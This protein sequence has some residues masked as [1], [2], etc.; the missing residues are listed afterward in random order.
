MITI[1][2]DSELTN[3]VLGISDG[4]F[5][6]GEDNHA[7][8]GFDGTDNRDRI[9][10]LGEIAVLLHIRGD[11]EKH[12]ARKVRMS[13][14]DGNYDL[15][16]NGVKYDV[17]TKARSVSPREDFECSVTEEQFNYRGAEG[18]IFVSILK[19]YT[20]G[21]I[22]GVISKQD[23]E[24]RATFHRDGEE[25]PDNGFIFPCNAYN[26]KISELFPL[27]SIRKEQPIE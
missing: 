15:M 5:P 13:G 8:F 22:L 17:K 18:Y 16:I 2:I 9:G 6:A 23:F 20:I 12:L 25:D 27:S 14:P 7:G 26:I 19:D 3:R 10:T 4:L 21:Y 11:I 24:N 1:S